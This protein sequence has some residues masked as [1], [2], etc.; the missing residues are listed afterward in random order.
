MYES[1]GSQFFRTTTEIQSGLDTFDVPKFIM[2]FLT[3][4]WVTEIY[5]FKLNLVEKTGKKLPE[6]SRLGYLENIL[7]NN[8]TLS[9]EEEDSSRSLNRGGIADL[10]LLRTLL[11]IWQKSLVLIAYT[12][13]TMLV[14]TKKRFLWNMIAA[15]AVEN[16]GDEGGW[17]D[18]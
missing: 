10:I 17:P 8:F 13:F 5:T 1:S 14:Q 15:Q 16:D 7:G 4:L 6:S 3:I 18:I 12:R 2:N 11:A 9:N